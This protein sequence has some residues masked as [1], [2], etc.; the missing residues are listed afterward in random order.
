MMDVDALKLV[1]WEVL[2]DM[3][4]PHGYA[5]KICHH[6]QTNFTP[7][8]P[9]AP[10]P[11]SHH[12]PDAPM[13]PIH[14]QPLFALCEEDGAL[15]CRDCA[16]CAP[17]TQHECLDAPTAIKEIREKLTE[18]EPDGDIDA[19]IEEQR[20]TVADLQTQLNEATD[21]LHKLEKR[22]KVQETAKGDI[23]S[24]LEHS[25]SIP[26]PPFN[27]VV[28]QQLH[29][30]WSSLG[31]QSP[32]LRGS[33][34]PVT[35]EQLAW[36]KQ[37]VV[38]N[39]KMRTKLLMQTESM[40]PPASFHQC[41]DDKGPTLVLVMLQ[42]AGSQPNQNRG[43]KK[44]S[45]ANNH[46]TVSIIGGFTSVSWKSEYPYCNSHHKTTCGCLGYGT[47]DPNACLFSLKSFDGSPPVAFPLKP[48]CQQQAVFHAAAVG[49][50]FGNQGYNE[51]TSRG[52]GQLAANQVGSYVFQTPGNQQRDLVQGGTVIGFEVHS[53]N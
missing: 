2:R 44:K 43:K 37:N 5:L 11:S 33:K 38:K 34:M 36:L 7:S 40:P 53:C 9:L 48:G 10:P 32:P 13:C 45:S 21:E 28:L 3:G 27:M 15:L 19:E 12:Q 8:A 50:C 16:R 31:Q 6:V 35:K 14:D 20:A 23:K 1:N 29:Q 41:C 18:W 17:H 4:V 51:F 39:G 22:K 30:L 47:P 25:K 26:K 52:T 49:V 24:A 46:P 42:N